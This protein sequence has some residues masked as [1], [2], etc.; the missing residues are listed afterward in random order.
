[1]DVSAVCIGVVFIWWCIATVGVVSRCVHLEDFDFSVLLHMGGCVS[2]FATI[3]LFV[4]YNS[5]LTAALRCDADAAASGASCFGNL[6]VL[7][8]AVG[9]SA[10]LFHTVGYVRKNFCRQA[11]VPAF[12]LAS[13]FLAVIMA[14]SPTPKMIVSSLIASLFMSFSSGVSLFEMCSAG[15]NDTVSSFSSPV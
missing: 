14:N 6:M 10:E 8:F 11:A 2:L 7:G 4:T 9:A 13:I 1:M 3:G 5:G 15:G 12:C